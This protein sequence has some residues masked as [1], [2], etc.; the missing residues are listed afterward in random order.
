MPNVGKIEVS[1][2]LVHHFDDTLLIRGQSAVVRRVG[3]AFE[4]MH[5]SVA[6]RIQSF[7]NLLQRERDRRERGLS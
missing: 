7:V 2:R 1:L 4:G 5:D 3:F 6:I